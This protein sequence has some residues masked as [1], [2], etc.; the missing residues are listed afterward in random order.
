MSIGQV[1]TGLARAA[2]VWTAQLS[3]AQTRHKLVMPY[4][5]TDRPHATDTWCGSTGLKAVLDEGDT[6]H[7]TP[8]YTCVWWQY[9]GA[10][11]L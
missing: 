4:T 6:C 3:T 2:Q 10:E 11:Q 9:R 7:Q 5:R 8:V 1:N